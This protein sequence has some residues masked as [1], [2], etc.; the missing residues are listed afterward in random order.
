MLR[1]DAEL[2]S[3]VG[4]VE[5]LDGV[6]DVDVR[7]HRR[8]HVEPPDGRVRRGRRHRQR[9]RGDGAGAGSRDHGLR[10]SRRVRSKQL[11]RVVAREW[12]RRDES[13]LAR[14]ALVYSRTAAA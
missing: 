2:G 4:D 13:L 10:A 8:G 14:G 9:W 11:Q 5:R 12:W 6:G 3:D 7:G 1:R